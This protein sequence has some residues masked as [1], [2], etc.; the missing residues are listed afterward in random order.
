MRDEAARFGMLLLSKSLSV[1]L[2]LSLCT[3]IFSLLHLFLDSLPKSTLV[4]QL[5]FFAPF[6]FILLLLFILH[7][8]AR[9]L[10]PSIHF[11]LP[12]SSTIFDQ[13]AK[14]PLP[15]KAILHEQAFRTL[16]AIRSFIPSNL[17]SRRR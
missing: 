8:D 5:L 10:R 4:I 9:S 11:V 17:L 7:H 3:P 15:P 12:T 2:S 16:R 13:A 14:T 6:P 1:S